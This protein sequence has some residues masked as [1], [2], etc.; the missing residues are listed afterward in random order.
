MR[1]K[2]KIINLKNINFWKA[3]IKKENYK[4]RKF[5]KY[6]LLKAYIKLE[7]TIKF[8]HIEIKKQAF[9]EHKEP[10]S[11]KKCSY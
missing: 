4:S 5:K 9:H 1:K 6:K 2:W 10:I 11:V 7:K 8:G 3:Y